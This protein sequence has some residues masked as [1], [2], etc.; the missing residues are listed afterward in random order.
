MENNDRRQRTNPSGY[1]TQQG[2]LQTSAQY[3]VVSASDRFRQT[4]L[5]AQAPTTAPPSGSRAT[6]SYGYAY[7]EGS[8]FVGSSIQP[9]GVPY[10]TQEYTP[11]QQRASQQQYS[12]YGGNVMYNVP[13]Q[14]ASAT[15]QS[16]Y[17][18]VQQYQPRQN[19]AIEVLSTGFGVQPVPQQY[20]GVPGEGGP[21]SAPASALAPQNV[22]SQYPSMGYTTQQS[23][24]GREPLAPSYTQPGMSDPTQA[25]SQGPY[26]QPAPAS[27]G[28]QGGNEYDDF[29]N[30]YQTELKKTFEYTRDGR[31]SE[32]A[33][34]LFRLSDWLLHWAETLGL[35][36]DEENQYTQRLKLWEEFNNCW[37]T[38]LQ[39]QKEVMQDMI[40][41]GQRPQPPQSLIDPDYL[42]K[43]GTQLVK[44]CDN[45]EKHGL[46]DY[47]MGVWEEEIIAML[48]A[49]L[50]LWEEAGIGSASASQRAPSASTSRRR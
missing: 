25:P 14:Q 13:G 42:E 20:Y 15:P 7:A 1:A 49:C 9:S 19:T 36:R 41:T 26:A 46:V 22:P 34:Q 2:L 3:P 17:E 16:P 24:V 23:P 38:T 39:R 32:A 37:L 29:Y 47:Q 43:M 11:E 28:D 5:A 31:L 33:A 12:Q 30:N 4:P 27:Y 50:D 10:G 48:T 8:Q 40:T 21:T 44:N 18:S 6:Q 35:V 45:M